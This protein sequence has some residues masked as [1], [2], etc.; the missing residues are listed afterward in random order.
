MVSIQCSPVFSLLIAIPPINWLR[1]FARGVR[2]ASLWVSVC[3]RKGELGA[4]PWWAVL[5]VLLICLK[6]EDT[7]LAPLAGEEGS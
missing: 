1:P 6:G 7:G 2:S 5:W 3:W 4:L